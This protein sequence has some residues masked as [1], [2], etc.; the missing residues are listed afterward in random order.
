MK[1]AILNWLRA[2]VYRA[3]PVQVINLVFCGHGPKNGLLSLYN[4][5]YL[6][7]TEIIP[8][9]LSFPDNSNKNMIFLTC[10]AGVF[11]RK[12]LDPEA[13]NILIHTS[14]DMSEAA[15]SF[16]SG[17]GQERSSLLHLLSPKIPS[18]SLCS[19]VSLATTATKPHH[20]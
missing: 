4:D 14:S 19:P 10:Y 13:K 20:R 11:G 5:H 12:V 2:R 15:S 8:E 16:I 9:L 18:E 7:G 1:E 6:S 17:S 3:L